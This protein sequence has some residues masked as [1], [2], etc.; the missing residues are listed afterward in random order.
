MAATRPR[1]AS[2]VLRR[3]V[4]GSSAAALLVLASCSSTDG[5]VQAAP[6]PT[7]ADC[8]V[9]KLPLKNPGRF[10]VATDQ[11]AYEPWYSDDNPN[12]GKGYE[13]AVAYAIAQ[14]LGFSRDQVDWVEVGFNSAIAAGEKTFDIDLDQISITARRRENVDLSVPYYTTSQA[15]VA[16]E[17]SKLAGITTL[18]E[19]RGARLGAQADS[20]SL[21][22][23]N[24][25]IKP[26][27]PAVASATND[28]AV[29]ALTDRRIDGLVVD[30]PTAIQMT[31]GQIDGGL[32][33]GRL[34]SP[35]SGPD[36]FGVA[37][38]HG[39]KLTPCI[40]Q[41]IN[42][43]QDDGTLARLEGRWLDLP[44]IRLLQ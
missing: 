26:Q 39:S 35:P 41:T 3:L 23:I 16:L 2:A 4:A 17:G 12:T 38:D 8:R 24:E 25:Q 31:S 32:M 44:D 20:T 11:P 40:N 10:T 37:L 7:G 33:V 43:L 1:R 19:L 28:A 36:S 5:G 13:S 22:A 27:L 14:Q 6:A 18:D 30:L 34:P 15:V 9:A 29:K 42:K 21:A